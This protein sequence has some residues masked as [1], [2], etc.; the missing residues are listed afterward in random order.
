MRTRYHD[1]LTTL[2][3]GGVEFILVGGVAANLHG[4]ARATFDLDVVY[5][6]SRENLAR[7]ETALAP[8][9]PYLRGAPPGLPF[10]LDTTTL[11]NGLNFT[12]TTTSGDLDILGEIAGGRTYEELLPH[13]V[14]M[15][16]GNVRF[17]CVT[18]ERLIVVKN[19]AGRT[20]DLEVL[21]ELRSLQRERGG[22]RG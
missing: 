15:E 12:L 11:R 14:L 5:A 10:K 21:A 22:A 2:V 9:S 1:L 13:S 16:A 8:L 19:A 17:R 18:L 20:K 6:R 4:S 3:D 7:M